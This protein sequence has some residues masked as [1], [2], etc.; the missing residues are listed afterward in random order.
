M[1]DGIVIPADA[2]PARHVDTAEIR[3][4]QLAE[5]LGALIP[6]LWAHATATHPDVVAWADRVVA[7]Q[8]GS[9]L[10]VGQVG[11]GKSHEAY[12]AI[13]RIVEAAWPRSLAIVAG[14]APDLLDDA[15][16][17]P[18]VDSREVTRRY[19]EADLL[20]LDDVGAEKGSD[21]VSEQ[22]YR[23]VDYR[24]RYLLPTLVISNLPPSAPKDANVHT[25]AAH[26][27]DRLFSR[28][29]QMCQTVVISG[30]DRRKAVR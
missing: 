21:W 24:Y 3:G 16:P 1:P 6:P 4:D 5:R 9:L 19:R 12:G 22:L 14:P 17:S 23:I 30:P 15:R 18:G 2:D 29:C 26:L 7:G 20:M 27:G 8:P 11:R 28:L 25:L 10:L 13:R